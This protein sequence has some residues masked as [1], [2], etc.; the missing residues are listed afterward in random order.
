MMQELKIGPAYDKTSRLGPVV[1][2]EHR[3]SIVKWIAEGVDE[4]AALVLDGR[5]V[6]VPGYEHGFYLGPTL[7]DHVEPGMSIGNQ[8]I[9]DQFCASS[10]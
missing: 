7:F 1:T 2:N 9:F 6:T 10:A 5:N 4:G 3:Q 8:E